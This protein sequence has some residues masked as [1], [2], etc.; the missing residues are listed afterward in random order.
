MSNVAAETVAAPVVS[1]QTNASLS[2]EHS[3]ALLHK[4][5]T[6]DV[7]RRRFEQNPAATLAEL[8]VPSKIIMNLMASCQV[9][10]KL[11][12]KEKFAKARQLLLDAGADACIQ[13]AIPNPKLD[14]GS[15]D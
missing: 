6:D 4:L 9:L 11:A 8:G 15:R 14:F 5:A 13:M 1:L 7:F 2:R 12:D 3:L 10:G